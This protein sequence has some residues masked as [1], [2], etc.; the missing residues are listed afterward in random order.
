MIHCQN[1][2]QLQLQSMPLSR[3]QHRIILLLASPAYQGTRHAD[4]KGHG[5][6]IV[7][8]V[9]RLQLSYEHIFVMHPLLTE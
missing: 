6:D 9:A 7:Y 3:S 5:R 8:A 4:H 1:R 2:G